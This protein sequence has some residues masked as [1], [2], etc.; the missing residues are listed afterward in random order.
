MATAPKPDPKRRPPAAKKAA[1]SFT[2]LKLSGKAKA[3]MDEL[4]GMV[5]AQ[6]QLIKAEC[7]GF[8]TDAGAR[9]RRA[10]EA[11]HSFEFFAKTYFPHYIKGDVSVFHS[12]FY[13][14][15][16]TL[17]DEDAGRLINL[18]APRGEAKSTLGT[19]LLVLWCIVTG[20]KHFV[21]IVMDSWDQSASMLEAI[22]TELTD[23]PR[24]AMDFPQA[25]GQG[26]VWNAGVI[27]TRND[28]K[29]QAFGS[30]K[31]MRG[32]R[33]GP[34]RPDLVVLDDIENDEN[35]RSLEQRDK[36]TSWVT[37][38]VLN[39]GPPD[40]TMDV[41]YLNTILHYDSVANRFHKKPRWVRRKFKAI[42]RFPDRMD[43]WEEWEALFLAEASGEDEDNGEGDVLNLLPKGIGDAEA[44][45]LRNRE[46]MER[47]AIVSWP[48]VRPLLR[49][50]QIRA[51]DHHAFDCEFQN[52]PTNE[53]ATWFKDLK[54]WVQP[55][56]DWLFLGAH[57]PSLGRNNKSRDPS[58][59]LVGGLDRKSG[60]L[61]VVEAKVIRITPTKQIANL[62][63]AQRAY[64]CQVWGFEAI[65][66]QE[67]MRTQ[68]VDASAK[69]G[70]PVPAMPI[71][72][73]SDK[74]LRIEGLSPHVYNGLIR[75]HRRFTVL[76]EQ[77]LNYPEADHDDGPDALQILW[78]LAVARMGKAG[79]IRLGPRRMGIRTPSTQTT[80]S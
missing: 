19:Q 62:I 32:L 12:W 60:V 59:M 48:S 53:D 40:G 70:V 50:M 29:L 15:V 80:E 43:L 8:P 66:F 79:K 71:T 14:N 38:T 23:N 27:L 13:D 42:I 54:Y 16:P 75:S 7:E 49:L 63:E 76:N 33:H 6:R 57:D 9:D 35:V 77:L 28:V 3:F 67:F 11:Q 61:D 34:W 36:L 1:G 78:T 73:H 24:L 4:A 39:L 58:A 31:K 68:L 21:P 64:N 46:Q 72:P 20:R 45:Y 56:R 55:C 2:A 30:G 10:T 18:S 51:E 5:E 22:K 69:A 74:E 26:R 52:N 41:L 17:I 44:F 37:K 25:C 65:Q 47:G